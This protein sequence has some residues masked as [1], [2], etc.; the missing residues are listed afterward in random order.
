[1]GRMRVCSLPGPARRGAATRPAA[2]RSA[3][4]RPRGAGSRT[5]NGRGDP[6]DHVDGQDRVSAE[7]EEVR[8]RHR[9]GPPP[10]RQP[11]FPATGPF[12]IAA[13][14]HVF[15]VSRRP[16]LRGR[17]RP[18]VELSVRAQRHLIHDHECRRPPCSRAGAVAACSR[19]FRRRPT[20]EPVAAD[21]VSHQPL[22]GPELSCRAITTTSGRRLGSGQGSPRSPPG[23]TPEPADLDLLVSP[24]HELQ[25]TVGKPHRTRSPVRYIR[26]PRR[27]RTGLAINRWRRQ[28]GRGLDSH[29]AS[30]A[31]RPHTARPGTPAGTGPQGTVQNIDPGVPD[32]P[33]D[34]RAYRLG[35]YRLARCHPGDRGGRSMSTPPSPR[36]G[37]Y[38][39]IMP[40]APCPAAGERYRATRHPPT[41]NVRSGRQ[42][43]RPASLSGTVAS[44]AGGIRGRGSPGGGWSTS[45]S[46]SPSRRTRRRY[47]ERPRR[48]AMRCTVRA[49]RHRSW[50]EENSSNPITGTDRITRSIAAGRK[51]SPGPRA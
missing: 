44:A 42:A 27:D 36:S 16:P 15:P 40:A 7:P 14:G 48:P 21:D 8:R 3:G 33:S 30:P 17:Q 6:G 35:R 34:W 37:P 26:V 28:P 24:S 41:I 51:A 13:G 45:A 32:R 25:L 46:C 20:G 11:R 31:A 47:D 5:P 4:R 19:S 2:P 9:R 39:L 1:M 22:S 50:G 12:G 43:C 23:S 49:R 29:A 10:A 38:E 18:P